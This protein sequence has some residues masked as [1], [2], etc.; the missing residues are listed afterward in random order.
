LSN[1]NNTEVVGVLASAAA[2]LG[3]NHFYLL[4]DVSAGHKLLR[5]WKSW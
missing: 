5:V 4:L 3:W 2:F 1:Y